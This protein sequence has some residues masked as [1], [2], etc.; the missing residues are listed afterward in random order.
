MDFTYDTF[1]NILM[2]FN[3]ISD[4]VRILQE[5]IFGLFYEFLKCKIDIVV[6]EVLEK[7]IYLHNH[8]IDKIIKMKI[9]EK[10]FWVK[11]E[12]LMHKFSFKT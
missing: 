2:K 3:S 12:I 7:F 9:Y 5:N 10:I 8:F 4:C 6:V 1:T 11:S